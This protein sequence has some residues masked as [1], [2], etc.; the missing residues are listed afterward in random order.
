MLLD[1]V[2]L[3]RRAPTDTLSCPSHW[4]IMVAN[5]ESAKSMWFTEF[6]APTGKGYGSWPATSAT[7][8][9]LTVTS[10]SATADDIHYCHRRCYD[11]RD[12]QRHSRRLLP[13]RQSHPGRC[14]ADLGYRRRS[15]RRHHCLR[16]PTGRQRSG[17]GERGLAGTEH[18]R[19]VLCPEGGPLGN[20][21]ATAAWPY[22]AALFVYCWSDAGD[23]PGPYGLV[24][25]D[26][27]PKPALAA[28]TTAAAAL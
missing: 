23:G 28:L 15:G 1:Q 13:R 18:H 16:V 11:H 24:R 19:G 6:G 27:T 17:C 12:Q 7:D 9:S 2:G 21:T 8:T 10:P 20:G 14:R 25:A 5:G 22:V 26:G 3:Q 4:D